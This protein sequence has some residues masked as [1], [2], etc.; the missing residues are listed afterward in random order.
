MLTA[1]RLD[2]DIGCEQ[3]CQVLGRAIND[4]RL[5]TPD[6]SDYVLVIDIK[7]ITESVIDITPKLEYK[8]EGLT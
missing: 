7:K 1:I 4:Y 8:N 5:S 2:K 6:L 3:M